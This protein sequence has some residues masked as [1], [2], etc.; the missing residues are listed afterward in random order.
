LV[1]AYNERVR[2]EI[3]IESSLCWLRRVRP[4]CSWFRSFIR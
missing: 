3:L 2:E 1:E 4:Y